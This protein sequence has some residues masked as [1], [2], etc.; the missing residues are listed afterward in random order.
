MHDYVQ[1]VLEGCEA[2]SVQRSSKF[3][4]PSSKGQSYSHCVCL[5]PSSAA[6]DCAVGQNGAK[7]TRWIENQGKSREIKPPR[8]EFFL[9]HVGGNT[10]PSAVPVYESIDSFTNLSSNFELDRPGD[11]FFAYSHFF[12]PIYAYLRL[13]TLNREKSSPQ[14]RRG[15]EKRECAWLKQFFDVIGQQPRTSRLGDEGEHQGSTESRP[16]F[17]SMTI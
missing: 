1:T 8:G 2:P 13:F 16:T 5:R 12:T 7:S 15:A 6:Q 10:E 3:Q 4:V 17:V 14:R 9:E 11:D